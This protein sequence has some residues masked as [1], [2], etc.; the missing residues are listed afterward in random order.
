M[1]RRSSRQKIKVMKRD[2]VCPC[3]CVMLCVSTCPLQSQRV[4]AEEE[5]DSDEDSNEDDD[6]DDD[7]D[8]D[9]GTEEEGVPLNDSVCPPGEY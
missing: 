1:S 6:W 9:S 4:F 7:D 3:D 8:Y 5:T 2:T